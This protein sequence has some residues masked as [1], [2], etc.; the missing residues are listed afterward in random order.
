MI[1]GNFNF[2]TPLLIKLSIPVDKEVISE[3]S[4]IKIKNVGINKT[5]KAFLDCLLDMNANIDLTNLK[6]VRESF[7]HIQTCLDILC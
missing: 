4:E 2:K 5:R 6:I 3:N 1:F 7:H